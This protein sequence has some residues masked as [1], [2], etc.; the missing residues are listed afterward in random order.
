MALSAEHQAAL[1]LQV[2]IAAAHQENEIPRRAHE[3]LM[4]KRRAKLELVRTAKDIITENKRNL[5]VS[6]RQ[7][8]DE[9]VIAYATTLEAYIN[10]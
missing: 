10:A 8:T 1:D 6:D 7:I 3:V 9:E 4:D 5:P 2:A